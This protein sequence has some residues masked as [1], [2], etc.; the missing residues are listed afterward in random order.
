MPGLDPGI[1]AACVL[2]EIA[3]P[4][5]AM[6]ERDAPLRHLIRYDD[7][8]EGG[9]TADHADHP[10]RRH[11]LRHAA[12]RAGLRAVGHARP[13]EFHQSRARRLRHGGRLFHRRPG[14]PAGRAVRARPAARVFGHGG[15]RRPARAHALC[16]CL[17]QEPS[18]PGAVHHRARLHVGRR[19]RLRDGLVAAIRADPRRA[20]RPVQRVRRRHGQISAADHRDLRAAHGRR[21]SG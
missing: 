16:A 19:G 12:V 1:H 18:R 9:A 13:D 2:Y 3:G 8:R 6:S 17:C 10:V 4:S 7:Q 14:Q 5:P 21:C 15:D 20:A 11:C